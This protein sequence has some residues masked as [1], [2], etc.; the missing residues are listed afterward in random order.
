MRSI[1]YKAVFSH[2]GG[3]AWATA[4]MPGCTLIPAM[5]TIK[6]LVDSPMFLLGEPAE[7]FALAIHTNSL[8]MGATSTLPRTP[9]DEGEWK[10]LYISYVP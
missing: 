6:C 4:E 1:N 9:F 3:C 7:K 8:L 10:R 5:A 2:L